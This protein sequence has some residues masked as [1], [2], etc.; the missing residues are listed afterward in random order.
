MQND[1][2][3]NLVSC[4]FGACEKRFRFLELKHG[5][6][7]ESG[8][9][10]YKDQQKRLVAFDTHLEDLPDDVVAAAT[11]YTKNNHSIEINYDIMQNAIAPYLYLGRSERFLVE[12]VLAASKRNENDARAREVPIDKRAIEQALQN[13]G[14]AI[15]AH[16]DILGEPS[17]K[18]I[19]RTVALYETRLEHSIRKK[20]ED[21]LKLSI[22]SASQAFQ[23]KNFMR[24]I[25]LLSPYEPHLRR[26]ERKKLDISR[27][28]MRIS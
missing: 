13:M 14:Q 18:V 28:K 15:H 4:F 24:V 10:F 20:Y 3:I 27:S 9:Y 11:R 26:T 17:R 8:L 5:F 7:Y 6:S 2:P 21:S 19:E 12:M 22:K 23:Q 25:S 16:M 1:T